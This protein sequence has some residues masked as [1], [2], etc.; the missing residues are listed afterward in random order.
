MLVFL[1]S[2]VELNDIISVKEKASSK[3]LIEN[4]IKN[5][6]VKNL[7]NHLKFDSVNF[8]ATIL[9]YCDRDDVGLQFDELL[10]IEYYSR[11]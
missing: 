10:V 11:R 2:N 6:Q 3:T 5:N 8:K 1:V 7:P 9:D 4:N